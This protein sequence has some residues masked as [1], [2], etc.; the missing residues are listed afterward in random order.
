MLKDWLCLKDRGDFTILPE[1][2]GELFFGETVLEE[3]I[4]TAIEEQMIRGRPP[5]SV[6]FGDYGI[7]KTHMLFHIKYYL[8]KS[9]PNKT[10]VVYLKLPALD[11]D[12]TFQILHQRIME[13]VGM[14]VIQDLVKR[15]SLML[16]G[17]NL[18]RD[19]IQFFG[20]ENFAKAAN[21]LGSYG[22]LAIE[23]WRWMCGIELPDAS[24]GNIGVTRNLEQPADYVM[25][26]ENVGKLFRESSKEESR[27]LILL[28]DECEDLGKIKRPDAVTNWEHALRELSTNNYIGMIFA[29]STDQTSWSKT[30]ILGKDAIYTRIVENELGK[31][32]LMPPIGSVENVRKFVEGML[33]LIDKK[34]AAAKIKDN[35]LSISVDTYPFDADALHA[36]ERFVVETPKRRRPRYII[37]VLNKLGVHAFKNKKFYLTG[38]E[39]KEVLDKYIE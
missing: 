4:R 34:C 23:A 30:P 25:V 38:D 1:R 21:S 7:G 39:T 11:V 33:T 26:L 12:S 19:L 36:I 32:L 22:N 29:L 17:P 15:L 14:S 28:I 2:D 6:I 37:A 10:C 31:Y 18:M 3:Q 20:D 13:S 16:S 24:Q 8:E 27:T 9:Y 5:K 35:N